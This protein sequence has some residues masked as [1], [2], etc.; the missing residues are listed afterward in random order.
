MSESL[1]PSGN[2]VGPAKFFLAGVSLFALKFIVDRCVSAFVFGR[3]WSIYIYLVPNE[4]YT[5]LSIPRA[6]RAFYLTML[7]IALPFVWVGIALTSRRLRDAGLP[8]WLV[9]LFFLPAGN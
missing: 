9:V 6:E 7:A 3:P 1:L 4:A 8:P 2:R 5:L